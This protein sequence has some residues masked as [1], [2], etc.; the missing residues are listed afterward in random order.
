MSAGQLAE[1]LES[2]A[3]L[4]LIRVESLDDDVEEH[5]QN[6]RELDSDSRVINARDEGRD[7]LESGD[8]H[9]DVTVLECALKDLH[10]LALGV[11]E[12]LTGQVH[13]AQNLE[14]IHGELAALGGLIAAESDEVLDEHVLLLKLRVDFRKDVS[15]ALKQNHG[16]SLEVERALDGRLELLKVR[17]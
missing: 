15:L 2:L 8:T 14:D 6:G 11:G 5:G 4:V 16:L 9:I 17:S 12:F 13:L 7:G 1:R 3:T 10:E